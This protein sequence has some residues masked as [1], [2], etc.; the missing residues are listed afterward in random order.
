MTLSAQGYIPKQGGISFRVDD[1]GLIYQY[2]D[3]QE[4]FDK[5]GSKFNFAVNLSS[6]EFNSAEFVNTIRNLQNNGHLLMDH[7]PSHST[8]YFITKFDTSNYSGSSG[9]DHIK[10]NKVCLR[11]IILDSVDYVYSGYADLDS[12]SIHFSPQDFHFLVSSNELDRDGMYFYFPAK[13][14]MILVQNFINHSKSGEFTDIWADSIKLTADTSIQFLT[15]TRDQVTITDDAFNLLVQESLLLCSPGEFNLTP[16][17]IWIQPGGN[18]PVLKSMQVKSALE[19]LG[20]SGAATYPDD[21]EKVYNEYNPLNDRQFAFQWGDFVEDEMTLDVIKTRIADGAAKH[22]V[23][24]NN[25]HWYSSVGGDN[26]EWE[27]YMDKMDSLLTWA[28]TNSI[29]IKTYDDWIDILYSQTPDPYENIIPPLNADIDSNNIPDGYR[30]ISWLFGDFSG[31][32]IEDSTALDGYAYYSDI[33]TSRSKISHIL[34][35]GGVE[36]GENSF[37]IWTKGDPGNF[38][39]VTFSSQWKPA[40]AIQFVKT[41]K[42]PANTSKWTK[43][44]LSQSINGNTSLEIPDTVSLLS[45]DFYHVSSNPGTAAISGM[46]MTKKILNNNLSLSLLNPSTIKAGDSIYIEVSLN[47]EFGNP[48]VTSYDFNIDIPDSSSAQLLSLS[49]LSFNSAAKDTIIIQDTTSE[50]FSLSAE[51]GIDQS[52]NAS[53][54]I[55]IGPG[56]PEYFEVLSS[57]DSM[58]IGSTRLIKVD[59]KDKYLN[60]IP[61]TPILFEVING[62]GSFS[63]NQDSITAISNS[64]GIS[65]TLFTADSSMQLGNDSIQFSYLS[66]VIDTIII[67]L[68]AAPVSKIVLNTLNSIPIYDCDTIRVEMKALD[69]YNNP[70]MNN[71]KFSFHIEGSSSAKIIGSDTLVFN[72][73]HSDTLKLID[74]LMSEFNLTAKLVNDTLITDTAQISVIYSKKFLSLKLMLEGPYDSLNNNMAA[75]YGSELPLISPYSEA[76]DTIES[77]PENALDWILVTLL[78]DTSSGTIPENEYIKS[79][80]L[81]DS[82]QVIDPHTGENLHFNIASDLYF[83]LIRHRNHLEIMSSS[84]VELTR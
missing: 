9:V 40:P 46:E 37:S 80:I 32:W 13:D 75:N 51:L 48:A 84:K 16:P 20:F 61:Q 76:P 17:T 74:S 65:E 68:K 43:Y 26:E 4:L 33:N 55:E 42:F 56:T 57:T 30:N 58:L 73:A 6:P 78:P 8:S 83:I 12:N 7:T 14:T 3:Y 50:S 54:S 23:L 10:S 70:V 35:M 21:A 81:T 1:N 72:N 66:T 18:F 34:N 59:V 39:E 41:F 24:I 5:Y 69:I 44:D 53:I 22:R 77:I 71:Q 79:A 11:H 36:K 25:I 64:L 15:Y 45:L 31:E 38:V 49:P 19:N 2:N 60:P 67:P 27:E 63:N 82:G 52:V 29:P 28:D 62:N 47:D